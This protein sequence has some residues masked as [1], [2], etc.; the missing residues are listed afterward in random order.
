[1]N[2]D[3]VF[4]KLGKEIALIKSEAIQ[5]LVIKA[6]TKVKEEFFI[7][8]ASSTGKH[9]PDYAQGEGGLLRH[10]QAAVYFADIITS[11]EMFS[12]EPT[13]R[14]LI[15]AA[16][17]LHDTCKGGVDWNR[18]YAFEH[19]LLVKELLKEEELDEYEAVY[20][21]EITYLISSHM[22]QWTTSK[23]SKYELPKPETKEQ[24]LVHLCDYLAS[25]K[26]I[27]VDI[28]DPGFKDL[29]T[30]RAVNEAS[31]RS[32]MMVKPATVPQ[33]KYVAVLI[34][35][36]KKLPAYDPKYND[37]EV[38]DLTMGQA[39]HLIGTLREFVGEY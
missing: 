20:W 14:D 25:R 26:Q 29:A 10:V 11:L 21:D 36:A 15:I 33:K 32:K 4:E 19:P 17:I 22:G 16:V 24:K 8:A 5:E 39:S 12:L 30:E 2:R 7:V 1:M 28:F 6:L 34:N 13:T 35:K 38:E 3:F 37:V 31:E 9:H 18:P 23:Y 27:D